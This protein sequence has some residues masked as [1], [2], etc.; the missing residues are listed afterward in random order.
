MG[1]CGGQAS[2]AFVAAAS[3]LIL[4]TVLLP[5]V[6]ALAA[7]GAIGVMAAVT[8][9]VVVSGKPTAGAQQAAYVANTGDK[10][11]HM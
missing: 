10:R 11:L 5:S 6:E 4:P 3:A 1:A 8:V 2:T 7:L 9:G